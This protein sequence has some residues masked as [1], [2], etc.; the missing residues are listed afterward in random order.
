MVKKYFSLCNRLNIFWNQMNKSLFEDSGNTLKTEKE[1][2][3]LKSFSLLQLGFSTDLA[4][5]LYSIV[6]KRYKTYEMART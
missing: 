5:P 6:I 1:D 2:L 4:S 3:H